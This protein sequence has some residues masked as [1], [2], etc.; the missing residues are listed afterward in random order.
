LSLVVFD[1]VLLLKVFSKYSERFESLK[2]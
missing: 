2:I 1:A